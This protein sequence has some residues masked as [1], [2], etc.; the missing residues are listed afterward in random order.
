MVEQEYY[1]EHIKHIS[2]D[3]VAN[4]FKTQIRVSFLEP[5]ASYYCKQVY[6]VKTFTSILEYYAS[7]R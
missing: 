5:L 4:M 3:M 6:D 1:S 7:Q 2:R